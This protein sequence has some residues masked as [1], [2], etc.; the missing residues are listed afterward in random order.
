MLQGCTP[1][2][3][4]GAVLSSRSSQSPS[5]RRAA[6]PR[7]E[8]TVLF[9][10]FNASTAESGLLEVEEIAHVNGSPE[11]LRASQR[12]TTDVTHAEDDTEQQHLVVPE[13]SFLVS[14]TS[15]AQH[16]SPTSARLQQP[17]QQ[18]EQQHDE[19][20]Q[21][22]S[23]G[24]RSLRAEAP[25][26][27]P[28]APSAGTPDTCTATG[29]LQEDLQESRHAESEHALESPH[30]TSRLPVVSDRSDPAASPGPIAASRH[31]AALTERVGT[32]DPP[33]ANVQIQ[34]IH[35]CLF[36]IH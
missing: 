34:C 1:P 33:Y 29:V 28:H 13:P 18:H 26:E 15:T 20:Q 5:R 31:D 14:D 17:P 30:S 6:D 21:Q 23:D 36:V 35:A 16:V 9:K 32:T 3:P 22:D 25:A 8:S 11:L 27:A 7:R 19:E 10:G 4:A 24:P 12:A 2:G